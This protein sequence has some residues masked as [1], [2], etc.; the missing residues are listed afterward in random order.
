MAGRGDIA[1]RKR[2]LR[3]A[4]EQGCTVYITAEQLYEAGFRPGDPP[5]FYRVWVPAGRR[6][7]CFVN[8]YREP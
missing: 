2:S 4:R 8:L 5:P 1:A 3:K 7:R 6:P